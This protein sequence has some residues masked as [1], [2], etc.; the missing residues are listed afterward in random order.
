LRAYE[1]ILEGNDREYHTGGSLGLPFPGTYEQEYN[2]FKRK[3][4]GRITAMTNESEKS[5]PNIVDKIVN[6]IPNVIEIYFH[7]SRAIGKGKR[8][9]DWDIL[10]IVDDSVVGSDYINT[11]FAL[12]DIAKEFKNFD[13]QPSKADNHISRIAKEEGKLLYS[14]N[15]KIDEALDSSYP[16]DGYAIG[17]RYYFE[18]E[19]G[20]F[21]KVYFQGKDLVEVSF[22]AILPGEEENFRPDK[23]TLTGTGNSRK[24]FGT[25]VKIVQDYLE[26]QEPNALYF[27]A[28]SSEPSRVKLYNTMISQVDKV[29]PD[30]YSMNNIDLGSGTAYMLKRKEK[31]TTES[32]SNTITLSDIY[33]GAY[34]DDDEVIWNYISDSDFNIPFTIQTIQPMILDQMLTMQY[35]VDD[36]ED[37]FDKMQPEQVEIIEYYKND[38]NL[39][40]QVIVLNQDRIIDGNHRAVAAV[41]ANKP[42]KYVDVSEE[43]DEN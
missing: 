33:D 34:P 5:F 10:V 37:L 9:S 39:S 11:V 23:T 43:V 27:S 4:P 25:V 40:H 24:V 7:G 28:D 29:L 13:I 1:F 31:V 14:V 15:Q 16:Y 32:I 42:I 19:D 21:Y 41:L 30:Y 35:G 6:N 3:G 18:T 2:M 17:G 38:P 26:K 12:Q 22:S 36:I 20:V 8:K